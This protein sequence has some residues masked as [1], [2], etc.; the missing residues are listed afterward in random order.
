VSK[1][2]D[3]IENEFLIM[4]VKLVFDHKPHMDLE[5]KVEYHDRKQIE[6][7][8]AKPEVTVGAYA[9]LLASIKYRMN[10]I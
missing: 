10:Q 3:V 8:I 9:H 6:D 5:E 4:R 7:D 1:L 2:D